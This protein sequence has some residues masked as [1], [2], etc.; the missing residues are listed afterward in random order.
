VEPTTEVIET[1][2]PPTTIE[3]IPTPA[4]EIPMGNQ[5]YNATPLPHTLDILAIATINS[6]ADLDDEV[7]EKNVQLYKQ[8]KQLLF[9]KI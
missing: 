1:P 5:K 4:P 7:R 8:S 2:D 9:S 3:S 6:D